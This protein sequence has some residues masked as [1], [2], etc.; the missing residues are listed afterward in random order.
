M[1]VQLDFVADNPGPPLFH[2]HYQMHMYRVQNAARA[3][4]V[5]GLSDTDTLVVQKELA[6]AYAASTIILRHSVDAGLA[7]GYRRL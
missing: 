5:E 4:T 7:S 1:S 3:Y 6:P 2:C